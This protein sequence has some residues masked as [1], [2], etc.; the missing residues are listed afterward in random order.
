VTISFSNNILHH[1]IS[2]Y[3]KTGTPNEIFMNHTAK[4]GLS[5]W[6]FSESYNKTGTP[7]EIFMNHTTKLGLPMELY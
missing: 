3:N 7:N 1:G 5:Q 4:L 6:N 2:K